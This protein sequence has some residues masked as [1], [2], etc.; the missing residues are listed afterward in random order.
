MS[1][2]VEAYTR[3]KNKLTLPSDRDTGSKEAGEGAQLLACAGVNGG[4]SEIEIVA[5]GGTAPGDGAEALKDRVTEIGDGAGGDAE[6]SVG[7]NAEGITPGRGT[8]IV[9]PSARLT[10]LRAATLPLKNSAAFREG[11]IEGA[12]GKI[13]DWKESA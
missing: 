2:R 8:E 4:G 5:G 3:K 11:S 12:G 1:M 10:S 13:S 7:G 6:A 9:L